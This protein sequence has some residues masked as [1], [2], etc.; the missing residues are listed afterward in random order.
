MSCTTSK[1]HSP[2]A[3]LP[4]AVAP[5][6]H[7]SAST[8]GRTSPPRGTTPSRRGQGATTPRRPSR[9]PPPPR[10]SG[11]TLPPLRRAG[12]SSQHPLATTPN[13]SDTCTKSS[14]SSVRCHSTR[15]AQ[16]RRNSADS[17]TASTPQGRT[18]TVRL[19]PTSA[20]GQG[21]MIYS[22]GARTARHTGQAQEHPERAGARPPASTS[23]RG[24]RVRISCT[25]SIRGSIRH[26][27]HRGGGRRLRALGPSPDSTNTAPT[28][29]KKAWKAL[30]RGATGT[31]KLRV[32]PLSRL[33]PRRLG[34]K[35]GSTSG[36]QGRASPPH[37]TIRVGC[38]RH[39]RRRSARFRTTARRL[40]DPRTASTTK[41]ATFR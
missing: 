41:E 11:Q 22:E 28:A 34:R 36:R 35:R 32:R 4:R 16:V 26:P 20:R 23:V 39:S 6:R 25:A 37:S 3:R 12:S 19:Q 8:Q 7:A 40:S 21:S 1:A 31:P 24:V 10:G 15:V 38:P 18:C 27:P 29:P 17:W 30:G 33:R 2:A 9:V 5:V 13:P 14:P